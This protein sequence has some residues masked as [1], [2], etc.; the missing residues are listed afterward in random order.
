MDSSRIRKSTRM[1]PIS[2]GLPDENISCIKLRIPSN[3]ISAQISGCFLCER[4]FSA[5]G[6][7]DP[8][9]EWTDPLLRSLLEPGREADFCLWYEAPRRTRS[10]RYGVASSSSHFFPESRQQTRTFSR[11]GK[12]IAYISYPGPHLCGAA[13]ATARTQAAHLPSDG[14]WISS[15]SLRTG[16]EGRFHAADGGLF[17]IGMEGGTPREDRR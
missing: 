15:P 14:C 12:W 1:N 4:G 7:T 2:Y 5:A 3:Q 17:L 10:L 9:H 11:D 8:A 13:A 6:Q 16:N